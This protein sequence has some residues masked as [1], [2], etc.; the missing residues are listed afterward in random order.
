MARP[1]GCRWAA[2]LIVVCLAAIAVQPALAADKIKV[3]SLDELPRFVYPI[4]GTASQLLV[5][6]Q[7]PAF[8]AR[9][10]KDVEQ[11]LAA[12]D[13]ADP[14]TLQGLHGAL[15]SAPEILFITAA[16]NDD[17]DVEFDEVIPSNFQLPNLITVAA[18]DQ[19]GDPTSFTSTGRN[20]VI[21]AN[22]YEVSSYVPGGGRM[23][24]SGTSM[25]SPNALNLAAKLF[26]LDPAVTPARVIELMK[27]GAT[28]REGDSS[29][30]LI[31]PQQ[32]VELLKKAGPAAT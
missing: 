1:G 3:T 31:N 25:A 7:F 27:K 10:R 2:L 12:Y 5:S 15:A 8:A 26:A 18:V 9:V 16:G 30:L 22:G 32:S 28:P 23:K 4:E 19:A 17:N 6:D 14:S 13:I 21:Y 29:F 24:A 11:V 20:V